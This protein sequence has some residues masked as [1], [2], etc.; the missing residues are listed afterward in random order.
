MLS[1]IPLIWRPPPSNHLAK[2]NCLVCP[3]VSSPQWVF[4]SIW[5][6]NLISFVPFPFCVYDNYQVASGPKTWQDY[7]YILPLGTFLHNADWC[8]CRLP[9]ISKNSAQL[10]TVHILSAAG[11]WLFKACNMLGT[12][13]TSHLTMSKGKSLHSKSRRKAGD[14]EWYLRR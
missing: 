8:S 4:T 12:D 6:C 14:D 13:C 10:V 5:Q 2:K 9:N 7:R 3:E 1:L 11:F